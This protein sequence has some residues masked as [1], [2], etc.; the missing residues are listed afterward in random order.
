MVE[1]DT[2]A[3]ECI[4]VAALGEIESAIQ[5]ELMLS[6]PG[7]EE[8]LNAWPL[9]VSQQFDQQGIQ[10]HPIAFLN[11]VQV[12]LEDRIVPIFELQHTV[13]DE[14]LTLMVIS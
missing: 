5:A 12:V 1:R 6:R 9:Y 13:E 8:F 3:I 14:E 4:A 11:E 7:W 10:A 2:A